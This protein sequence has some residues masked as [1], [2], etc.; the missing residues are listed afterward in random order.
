[1]SGC[2]DSNHAHTIIAGFGLPGRQ[3]ADH[4]HE[5]GKSFCV[6]E[7]NPTTVQ[8]CSKIH[9]PIIAGDCSDPE[10]LKRAGIEHAKRFI[11]A[12]PNERAAVEAT[13]QARQLNP[14][15]QIITR[16]HYTSTGIEA[17]AKGADEVIVAEQVVAEELTRK[18]ETELGRRI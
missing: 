15:I 17:K 5:M 14:S 4:L 12:I 9:V 13:A 7:L 8:R 1:M 10:V 16:C 11:I 2:E 18:I 3:V 6:I